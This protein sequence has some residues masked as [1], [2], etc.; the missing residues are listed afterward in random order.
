MDNSLTIYFRQSGGFTGMTISLELT[1]DM[2]SRNE[3]EHIHVLIEQAS[4][5]ELQ[6]VDPGHSLPDQLL[7]RISVKTATRQHTI[8]IYEHQV[9]SEL[10]PLI[11]FLRGKARSVKR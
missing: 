8:T 1:D 6:T 7:Y 2:L 4:F 10:Q 11:R 3:S 5:F 9:T